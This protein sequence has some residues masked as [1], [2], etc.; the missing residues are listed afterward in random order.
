MNYVEF[1]LNFILSFQEVSTVI[2][3]IRTAKQVKQNAIDSRKLDAS[4]F[5][6][7]QKMGETDWSPILKLMEKQG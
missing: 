4:H 1:A 7:L 3:G 2:P 5:D 6:Y